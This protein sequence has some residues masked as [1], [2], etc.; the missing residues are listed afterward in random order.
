MNED[1]EWE[2]VF[3][4]RMERMA[5]LERTA[6]EFE[7]D[8]WVKDIP[9]IPMRNGWLV[10]PIP[11]FIVGVARFTVRDKR[12]PKHGWVSVYLDCYEIA[13]RWSKPYW[14]VHPHDDDCFR[15]DMEDVD[16]LADAIQHSLD[17]IS[18]K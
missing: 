14:E 9:H 16:A 10:R 3:E 5:Y 11:P 18:T 15:C 7:W 1:P 12:S 17:E 4:S 2:K 13:G 8:K 6:Q